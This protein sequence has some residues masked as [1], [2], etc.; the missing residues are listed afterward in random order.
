MTSVAFICGVAPLAFARGAGA[1]LRQA[2]GVAVFYGMIGVTLFGLVF[3]PVFYVLC[4]RLAKRFARPVPR[5][6][7]LGEGAE[8]NESDVRSE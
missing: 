4:R 7:V 8:R 3:T 5:I 2:L 1:E 6:R